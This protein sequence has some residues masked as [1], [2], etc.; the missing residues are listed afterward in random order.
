MNN[1][2]RR[3]LGDPTPPP[4]DA[5]LDRDWE[6]HPD[7]PE[8]HGPDP[9][10][11]EADDT[12]LFE[13]AEEANLP[14]AWSRTTFIYTEAFAAE[15]V[16]DDAPAHSV[17]SPEHRAR[18]RPW[19]A[20]AAGL[21]LCVAI[22]AAVVLIP[23]R[24]PAQ[25]ADSLPAPTI[26]FLTTALPHVPSEVTPSL[27]LLTFERSAPASRS[28][29]TNSSPAGAFERAIVIVPDP[30]ETPPM[31]PA[32]SPALPSP[33]V[34]AT[35]ARAEESAPPPAPAEEVA[36]AAEPVATTASS[37]AGDEREIRSLLDAYRDSYDRRD[38]VSTARLWPG[39][40]TAALSRAF[41]TVA[42]QQIDF[43]RCALDVIGHRA[44][45][46]CDGSLQYTRRVGNSSPH[47]RSLSWD[48]ELDRS[49]GRWLIS[50]VTAQ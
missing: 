25:T 42:N 10:R 9:V 39:V 24:R 37:I 1:D 11:T 35:R 40:N 17:E 18:P 30:A 47:S 8:F 14:H 32:P 2:T 48:F 27:P 3:K 46:R 19:M 50:R 45:A 6:R 15:K 12:A 13:F 21:T 29:V 41:A 36:R 16:D 44:T 26:P 34:P 31:I 38:A 28:N 4:A 23:T 7:A 33:G 5:S 20:I 43:E 49:T 22:A